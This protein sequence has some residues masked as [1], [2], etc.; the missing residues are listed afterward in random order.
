MRLITCAACGETRPVAA[1][2]WCHT[3]YQRWNRNGRPPGGP[4]AKTP[5]QP[6]G[7]DAGYQRHVKYGE[8]I[9]D[10]CRDAH[11]A[12]QRERRAKQRA[13]S[14]I[15]NQWTDEQARAAR[16]ISSATADS[17]TDRRLLLEALGLAPAQ[18]TAAAGQRAA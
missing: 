16:V 14:T 10:R 2:D 5:L 8:P 1:H 6:C 13:K 3:C 9:D 17:P 12:A 18:D 4:P 11:N 15:R 7:T